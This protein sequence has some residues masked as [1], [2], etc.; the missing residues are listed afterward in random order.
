MRIA[1]A[2]ARKGRAEMIRTGRGEPKPTSEESRADSEVTSRVKSP[3]HPYDLTQAYKQDPSIE[4][5]LRIRRAHPDVEFDV[6][7]FGRASEWFYIQ[8][9]LER[10]GISWEL[11]LSVLEAKPDAISEMALLL[12]EKAS[13]RKRKAKGGGTHLVRRGNAIPDKLVD[14]IIACSLDALSAN[15]ELLIPRD[16]IV[17]IRERLCGSHPEYVRTLKARVMRFKAEL[18][19]Q[20]L[21]AKGIRPSFRNVGR[22]LG[23]QASTVKRWFTHPD[24]L[25]PVF[26]EERG[27]VAPGVGQQAIKSAQKKSRVRRP[28]Q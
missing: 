23:V 10:F 6:G 12:L 28:P 17:L 19:M 25:A 16:L 26:K 27:L 11:L 2:A 20:E 14:W 22:S 3:L 1:V 9:E 8:P 13:E 24:P 18:I 21:R 4:N 5:Y 7:I 15:D